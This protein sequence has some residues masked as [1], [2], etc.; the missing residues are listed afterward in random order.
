MTCMGLYP[1]GSA[2]WSSRR[3]WN[4]PDSAFSE[5]DGKR[6]CGFASPPS[7]PSLTPS[8]PKLQEAPGQ[9]GHSRPARSCARRPEVPEALR[10]GLP[11]LERRLRGNNSR[12]AGSA[13]TV[14]EG[15]N[16][17]ERGGA[18][19]AERGWG[20]VPSNWPLFLLPAECGCKNVS[21]TLQ[22]RLLILLCS[23]TEAVWQSLCVLETVHAVKRSPQRE[24]AS[25]KP[26]P[27][28]GEVTPE[29]KWKMERPGAIRDDGAEARASEDAMPW[30]VAKTAGWM[31]LSGVPQC[32]QGAWQ[33]GR[34]LGC[35]ECRE[36]AQLEVHVGRLEDAGGREWGPHHRDHHHGQRQLT[37]LAVR[38]PGSWEAAPGLGNQ[39]MVC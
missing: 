22:C 1:N 5:L 31:N 33:A 15:L 17:S 32:G 34:G 18:G 35:E 9:S 7:V 6:H 37:G 12:K 30:D 23:P 28:P 39:D 10:P 20:L 19:S 13:G 11:F 2:R 27:E 21:S 26:L 14:E 29:I 16:G 4:I 38:P 25:P 8:V 24:P 36:L 3:P